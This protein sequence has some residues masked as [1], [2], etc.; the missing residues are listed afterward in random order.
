[1]KRILVIDDD[2]AVRLA[3]ETVLTSA[4]YCVTCAADGNEGVRIFL[5]FHPDIV[6]TDVIMPVQE[7]FETILALRREQPEIKIIAMSGGGRVASTDFLSMARGF[8][9]DHVMA[10][11]FDARCADRCRRA[12]PL[13]VARDRADRSSLLHAVL[14]CRRTELDATCSSIEHWVAFRERCCG[15]AVFLSLPRSRS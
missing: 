5:A 11:P 6:I 13:A 12:R 1:M 4:G 10:K 15:C 2:A 9:A 8:G 14:L 7:G 3:I